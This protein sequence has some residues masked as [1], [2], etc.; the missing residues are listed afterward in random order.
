[1]VE[2]GSIPLAQHPGGRNSEHCQ[3]QSGAETERDKG[4][5]VSRDLRPGPTDSIDLGD[6][7]PWFLVST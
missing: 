2:S 6:A 5:W 4:G 3:P 1:M 7:A